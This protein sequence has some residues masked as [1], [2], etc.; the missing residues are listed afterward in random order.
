VG[1]RDVAHLAELQAARDA[2]E[3]PLRHR[4][5]HR[6][7]RAEEICAGGSIYWVIGG[8]LQAR[9]RVTDILED[10]WE[11]GSR[12]AGLV[13]D[14]VLVRVAARSMKPF[15]GWRYLS[16][17]DAPADV[18]DA[19]AGGDVLPEEMRLALARLALL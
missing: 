17:A 5:R 16:P 15:Q 13:L 18:A 12:C 1:V 11:D 10:N 6:P 3:P 8:V 14:K 7:K 19:G 4:T 2:R 9:Q